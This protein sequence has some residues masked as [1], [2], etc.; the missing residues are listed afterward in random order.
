MRKWLAAFGLVVV[1]LVVAIGAKTLATPSRQL[2][3]APATPVAVDGA[4]ASARL[5]AAVRL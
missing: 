1:A 2:V 5:G 4:A 3:V